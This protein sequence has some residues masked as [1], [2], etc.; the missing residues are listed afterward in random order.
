[1]KKITLILTA[2]LLLSLLLAACRS[3]GEES[4]SNDS[5]AILTAAAQTADAMLRTMAASTPTIKYVTPSPTRPTETP[6]PSAS[7]TAPLGTSTQ[8]VGGIAVGTG[9]KA[10]FVADV[11][12]PDY[13]VFA[14]NATFVK[15]WRLRNAGTTTWTTAYTVVYASGDSMNSPASVALPVSVPPGQ[16]VD[17]SVPMTAPAKDGSYTANFLLANALGQRFG[18]D[19][20]A[21]QPFYVVIVVGQAGTPGVLPTA[22]TTPGFS[23]TPGAGGNIVTWVFLSVDSAIANSCPHTYN[24]TGQITLNNPTTLTYQLEFLSNNPGQPVPTLDPATVNLPT[25]T[26][27]LTFQVNFATDFNGVAR[28]HVSAPE[29]IYSNPVNL[30]LTCPTPVIYPT[31]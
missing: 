18:L 28:L 27:T 5:S 22:T 17:V 15:T 29:N 31:P 30:V 10:E 13:T 25:G 20:S 14:P 26:H 21:S 2:M 24:F 7:P 19:P 4:S 1:M 16:T 9:D 8:F 23:G 3:S 11:S 12:V 6:T